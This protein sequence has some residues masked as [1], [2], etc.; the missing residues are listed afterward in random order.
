MSPDGDR[1]WPVPV[2]RSVGP[3]FDAV[4]V[5]LLPSGSVSLAIVI[6]WGRIAMTP[7]KRVYTSI[8][9]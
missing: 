3:I 8:S 4:D 7:Q 6:R 1:I 9:P 2:F 5:S